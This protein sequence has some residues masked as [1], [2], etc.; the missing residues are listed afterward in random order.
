MF[1]H[2][3][4]HTFL[5]FLFETCFENVERCKWQTKANEYTCKE[6]R[7]LAPFIPSFWSK[8]VPVQRVVTT[9]EPIQLGVILASRIARTT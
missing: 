2:T 3:Y 4:V 5:F 9:D 6:T 1:I 8:V 7:R